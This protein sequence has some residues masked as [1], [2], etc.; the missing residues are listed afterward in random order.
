M[1]L[2]AVLGMDGTPTTRSLLIVREDRADIRGVAD[3][4]GKSFAFGSPDS[5]AATSLR[6]TT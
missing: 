1:P 6:W 3:L 5:T 2:C 4:A